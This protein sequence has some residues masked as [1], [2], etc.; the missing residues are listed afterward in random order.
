MEIALKPFNYYANEQTYKQTEVLITIFRTPPG[1][2]VVKDDVYDSPTNINNNILGQLIN[3][4]Y[5]STFIESVN[6]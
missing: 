5:S 6:A 1:G 3:T 4:T 2:E